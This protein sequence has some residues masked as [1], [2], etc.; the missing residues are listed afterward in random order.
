MASNSSFI[1][2]F[3]C[4]SMFECCVV[5]TFVPVESVMF[6]VTFIRYA[7]LFTELATFIV[8]LNSISV[9][10]IPVVFIPITLAC[11][12]MM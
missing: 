12:F 11:A 5:F 1:V 7:V 8:M 9:G 2:V 3:S 4:S 10:S 6:R